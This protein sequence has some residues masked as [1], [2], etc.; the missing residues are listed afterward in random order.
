MDGVDAIDAIVVIGVIDEMLWVLLAG[1]DAC[2]PGQYHRGR[3]ARV[4][5]G[6]C[7]A[8][9]RP[10]LHYRGR[11]AC[12]PS[13]RCIGFS[14]LLLGA[15]WRPRLL[16]LPA[17]CPLPKG[18]GV[19]PCWLFVGFLTRVVFE[20]FS[21]LTRGELLGRRAID[22]IGAIVGIG[23]YLAGGDACAPGHLY[24]AAWRPHLHYRGRDARVPS[25]FRVPSGCLLHALNL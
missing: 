6:I 20:S 25:I 10:H 13:R 16:V 24:G 19:L 3:D 5:S 11:D 14:L 1:G 21:R 8:A 4:P 23:V 9:W 12:V 17:P 22:G 15:G 7:G 2:A 18:G